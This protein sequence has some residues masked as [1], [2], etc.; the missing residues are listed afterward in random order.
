M[1]ML[2]MMMMKMMLMIRMSAMHNAADDAYTMCLAMLHMTTQY[3]VFVIM[4][5]VIM[6][7]VWGAYNT[8]MLHVL[9]MSLHS[10][11]SWMKGD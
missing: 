6:V 10:G 7:C 11:I 1:M 2:L 4:V 3:G 8:I 9:M 5:V